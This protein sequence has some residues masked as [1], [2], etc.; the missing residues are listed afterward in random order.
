M[1]WYHTTKMIKALQDSPEVDPDDL[2]HIEW[3]YLPLLDRDR[4]SAPKLL[5]SRLASDPELF[6]EVIRLIY[7]SKKAD[8]NTSKSLKCISTF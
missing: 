3:A 1:D 4:G 7:R 6:C 2:F 5:E 8:V